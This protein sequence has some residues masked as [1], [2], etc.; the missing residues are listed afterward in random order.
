MLYFEKH[1]DTKELD[2]STL[3]ETI[4]SKELQ[5]AVGTGTA[6][7]ERSM[8]TFGDHCKEAGK[9]AGML[10]WIFQVGNE[11]VTRTEIGVGETGTGGKEK[12][13]I[14]GEVVVGTET[15]TAIGV[16]MTQ[17]SIGIGTARV[18]L[19]MTRRGHGHVVAAVAGGGRIVLKRFFDKRLLAVRGEEIERAGVAIMNGPPW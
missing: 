7:T 4:V 18:P 5:G 6:M 9:V 13:E 17:I 19:V 8:K 16:P 1:T 10:T 14:G 11:D 2:S 15:E 3:S 12:N